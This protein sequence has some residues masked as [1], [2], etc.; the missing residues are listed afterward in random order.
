MRLTSKTIVF[1]LM[2]LIYFSMA[3]ITGLN[4]PFSKVIQT[5]FSLSTFQSQ[6]GGLFFFIA[7]FF[8]GIPSSLFVDRFGCKRSVQTAMSV[9]VCSFVLV[10]L[11]GNFGSL[12]VYLSGM[13]TLGCAVTLLQVVVNPVIVAAGDPSGG[14]T[15]MNLGGAASS[16]G[17][18]LS[19]LI[20][21]FIMGNVAD[22]SSLSVS[23]VN[24]LIFCIIGIAIVVFI[25]ASLI[26]FPDLNISG[27]ENMLSEF[28]SLVNPK[29]LLGIVAIFLY[30]GM[31]VSTANIT[32]L[33]M[34]NE[35]HV[36]PTSAGAVVGTYWIFML[37]G[38]LVGAAVGTVIRS[39]TQLIIVAS[40]ALLLY[41]G[42]IFTP[43]SY[44]LSLPALDSDFNIVMTTL[45]VSIAMLIAV[46]FCN[47]VMWTCVFILA[48]Q[49]LG[50]STN[51]AA[52]VFMM[53]VFGGGVIPALQGRLVDVFGSFQPTYVVGAFC[54]AFILG[55]ALFVRKSDK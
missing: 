29:F 44:T 1:L 13:F 25:A 7:Y 2:V 32:N 28:R 40:V 35:L 20:V 24:P 6:L 11:G 52:G 49:G 19:P 54:L 37:V 39:R 45:P 48:T 41:L 12:V 23:D 4:D 17:A 15:R 9:V 3:F 16:I 22:F 47:S 14:N 42:A 51:L 43:L 53:M 38:R 21:G 18:T 50:R 31:E 27:G 30:V 8:V 46:G 26:T 34:L 33:F 10:L 36:D 5:Q 55:Y